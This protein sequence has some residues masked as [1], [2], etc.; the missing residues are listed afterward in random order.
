MYLKNRKSFVQYKNVDKK[1]SS[2]S[3]KK[4]YEIK[5]NVHSVLLICLNE[6]EM[7][8]YLNIQNMTSTRKPSPIGDVLYQ[9][10]KKLNIHVWGNDQQLFP[11]IV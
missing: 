11:H 2:R 8:I 5:E 1:G 9:L 10:T 6:K 7:S 3:A 4:V